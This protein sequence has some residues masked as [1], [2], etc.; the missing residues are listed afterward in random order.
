M[1]PLQPKKERKNIWLRFLINQKRL[2]LL[3]AAGIG[4]LYVPLYIFPY[5]TQSQTLLD[6]LEKKGITFTFL[7]FICQIIWIILMFVLIAY[8]LKP[9]RYRKHK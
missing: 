2:L 8:F 9:E 6:N 7:I 3:I 5:I 1:N 4:I